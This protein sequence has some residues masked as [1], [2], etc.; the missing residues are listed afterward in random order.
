M[1][2]SRD[3]EFA[4]IT[5]KKNLWSLEFVTQNKSR[6]RHHISL[7]ETFNS[8]DVNEIRYSL[9]FMLNVITVLYYFSKTLRWL[10]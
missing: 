4:I 1:S 5:P 6:T 8:H 2:E 9:Y 7:K 10:A 3:R